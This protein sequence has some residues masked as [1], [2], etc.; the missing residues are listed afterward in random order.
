MD[1]AVANACPSLDR[2]GEIAHPYLSQLGDDIING[3]SRI[4][5][6]F[7]RS[8]AAE[9]YVHAVPQELVSLSSEQMNRAGYLLPQLSHQAGDVH[10]GIAGLVAGL[11]NSVHQGREALHIHRQHGGIRDDYLAFFVQFGIDVFL[12]QFPKFFEIFRIR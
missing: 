12:V 8:F 7:H 1:L 11:M 4:G 5:G 6:S 9:K 2:R 3:L 10:R